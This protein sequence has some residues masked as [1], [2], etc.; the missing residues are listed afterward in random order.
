METSAIV[1]PLGKWILK[2]C[3]RC[4]QLLPK[5]SDD[6]QLSVNVSG[7]Q[8]LNPLFL[9]DLKEIYQTEGVDPRHFKLEVTE[10]VM[11][12]GVIAQGILQ[13]CAD[14]GFHLAIDDFGTGFS[15]LQFLSQMPVH[16]LKID[17]SFTSQIITD[18]KVASVV[19]SLVSIAKELGL[20]ITAE[21][22]ESEEELNCLKTMGVDVGQGFLY[23]KPVSFEDFCKMLPSKKIAV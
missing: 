16:S 15:S 18:S 20:S 6:F 22:I 19:R 17:R 4:F 21:G 11:M 9:E 12:N 3:F 10:R 5:V 13:A 1:V 2:E 8:F 23:S 14:L 7:K